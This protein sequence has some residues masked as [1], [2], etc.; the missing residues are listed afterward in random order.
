VT[1]GED[2]VLRLADGRALAYRNWGPTDGRP[3]VFFHGAPG[4]RLFCPD[5]GVAADF[6]LRLVTF[7]RP[8]FGRS[9][10]NE[11]RAVA[12][13]VPDVAA[14]VDHLGFDRIALAGVSAG[15]PHTLACARAFADRVTGVAV[16]S[17]PGPLDDVPGA[18]AGLGDQ[19][20]PTAE[21]ARA[22]PFRSRRA[23][24]RYMQAWVDDPSSYL[25][26]GGPPADRA[27]KVDPRFRPML[28]ADVAEALRGGAFGQ[29]DD[30]IAFWRPWG[31]AVG[32]VPA[33]VRVFH[34][35]QDSRAR[36]DF[37]HLVAALPDARPTVW[38]D[39]GHYGIVPRW[40]EF[41]ASVLE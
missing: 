7:D 40:S 2:Q 33:G 5:A 35:A 18:W 17:M 26:P 10:P 19:M 15:G 16:A 32:E 39:E 3:V 34:G 22:E 23:V 37:D 13:T 14:L 38:P 4:S 21:M 31:F 8:G 24:V 27:V 1:E 36:P 20:R 6:R 11:G 9:D 25:R 41:L 29:A 12:D 30:L 28:L